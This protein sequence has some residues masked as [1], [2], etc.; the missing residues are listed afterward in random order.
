[1]NLREPFRLNA[2]E[3]AAS[4]N[5]EAR[6]LA[7]QGMGHGTVVTAREQ[8]AGRGRRGRRWISPAGNLYASILLDPGPVAGRAAELAFVG[9][10]ALREA[11]AGLCPGPFAC[12][13]PNDI[14]HDGRKIAGMLLEAAEPL[15]ILGVGV[16]V[17]SAPELAEYPATSLH[18][19]GADWVEAAAV[20]AA[21]CDRLAPWYATWRGEG[22]APIRR[23]WL[24]H[25]IGLGGPV[26]VRLADRS[27][28]EGRFGGLDERGAL[29]LETPSG[30][31]PVLAGDVFFAA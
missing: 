5:D 25:A 28:M 19:C 29:L 20:L 27:S 22:F 14:L 21:F 17:T 18:A 23:A 16:N 1:M 30:T 9:A 8:T 6:R 26:V 4:T 3:R 2:L 12:K 13:W 24:A 7:G 11:L 15:V 10:L 31:R